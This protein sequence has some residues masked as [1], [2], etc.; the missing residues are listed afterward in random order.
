MKTSLSSKITIL[1]IASFVLFASCKDKKPQ[2][3]IEGKISNADTTI[4]YLEKRS[5]TETTIIDSVKLDKDGNFKFTEANVGYPEFYL[6]KLNGQTIN[7]AVDSIETITVNAPK[8]TFA[9]DYTVDGSNGSAKIKDIVLAQN[10]LSQTFSGLKKKFESKEISQD[11][12]VTAVQ[13][14]VNEYKTKAKDLIYSDYKSLAA[15]FALF[16]KVD[17]YLIFDPY[18]KKDIAAFQ[19]VATV[20]DTQYPASPRTANLKN[21]TLSAL[22]EIRKV[23]NQEKA[24]S[25][26]AT[27]EITDHSTYYDITLPDMHNKK[28]SLSSLRGKVVILDFTA[29]QTDFS[30]AHNIQINKAYEK[31]KGNV[32]VY[33][34]SFD[35]DVHV[36]Q[37]SAVNLPWICVREDRSLASN[38]LAKYNVQG[39]PTTFIVNKK[40]E[41]VKRVLSTDDLS[42]EVQKLL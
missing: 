6:L 32:E 24:I 27:S 4:L 25:R 3:T 19:A 33:Q 18:N 13:N 5:L 37:N 21:F 31:H 8:E 16:Q 9:M 20:W 34:I 1:A 11:E 14:G 41:I 38:L 30:P 35:T 10:K 28:I 23:A 39:F 42:S 40:G 22:V 7:L 26:I 17:N 12:Y 15:Y 36:W 2:F 29:Y